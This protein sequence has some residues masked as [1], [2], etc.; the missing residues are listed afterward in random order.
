M[1]NAFAKSTRRASASRLV[2]PC[3]HVFDETC[4][5][6]APKNLLERY[7]VTLL[8]A[9]CMLAAY[10]AH[11]HATGTIASTTFFERFAFLCVMLGGMGCYLWAVMR[12]MPAQVICNLKRR[13]VLIRYWGKRERAWKFLLVP[14]DALTFSVKLFP[15]SSLLTMKAPVPEMERGLSLHIMGRRGAE[16]ALRALAAYMREGAGGLE[17]S[18]GWRAAYEK[19]P[20]AITGLSPEQ[21]NWA[22]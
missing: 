6:V 21:E 20:A 12:R 15:R 22:R 2:M 1:T 10:L 14:W 11:A 18:E 8:A 7:I 19:L 9:G 3:P 16:T 13:E 4:L 17:H 5:R